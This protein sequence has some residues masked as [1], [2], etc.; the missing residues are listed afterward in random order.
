MDTVTIIIF[1]LIAIIGIMTIMYIVVYNKIQKH[2]IRIQEAESEIDETLRKRYDLLVSMENEIN[3]NTKLEQ[4]NF[5]DFKSDYMS[6]FDVDRRLTKINDTFKKI[7]DD[8]HDN[9]DTESFRKLSTEIKIVEEKSDAAKSYYN[10]YTTSLNMIIKRFP[11]NIIARIHKV[12]ERMYFDN[13]NMNDAN[14]LDF[15]L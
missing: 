12:E 1:A 11:S 8:F 5:N 9:L 13:K 2:I 14:I 15:K 4:N 10:K 3:S 6:T 7:W